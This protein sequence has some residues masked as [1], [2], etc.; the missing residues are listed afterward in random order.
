MH[1]PGRAHRAR[2]PIL[3]LA[4][5]LAVWTPLREAAAFDP[6]APDGLLAEAHFSAPRDGGND[7]ALEDAL[8]ALVDSVPP[9]AELRGAFYSWSRQRVAR[10]FVRAHER[11][12]DVRLVVDG[13][14]VTA[15]GREY[16]AITRLRD[17]LGERLTLCGAAEGTDRDAEADEDSSGGTSCIGNGI[18]HNKFVL[19]SGL[20]DGRGPVI[21]QT[22]TNPTNP[23]RRAFNDATLLVGDVALHAALLHYWQALQ[24]QDTDPARRA[25]AAGDARTRAH[26]FPQAEGDTIV[27]ILD[28]VRCTDGGQI[29]LAMARFTWPRRAVARKL[30]ELRAEG[31]TVAAILRE[32]YSGGRLRT[33]LAEGGVDLWVFPRGADHGVHSKYLLIDAPMDGGLPAPLVV[34]GSHNYTGPALRRHDELVLEIADAGLHATYL[35]NWQMLRARVIAAQGDD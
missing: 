9:G 18:Q 16:R 26:F 25:S 32:A 33:I 24:H 14:N 30:A 15:S 34:T 6:Q 10:A 27:D 31:C 8:I 17:G 35:E 4:L 19:V 7:D 5:L 2:G 28:R 1:H 3:L 29:H 13:G 11:G 12:V 21:W 22:S 20:E 23:Q